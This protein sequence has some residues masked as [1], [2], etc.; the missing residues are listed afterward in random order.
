[1][2]TDDLSKPWAIHGDPDRLVEA[3]AA[4]RRARPEDVFGSRYP[5][6]YVMSAVARLLDSL[7]HEM[8][9]TDGLGHDVVSAA[10]EL[11]EHVIAYVPRPGGQR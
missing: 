6:E 3:A 9:E 4:L 5:G 1:M 7:A 11:S 10:T 2:G 8:R